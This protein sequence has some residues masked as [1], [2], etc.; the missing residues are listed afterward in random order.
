MKTYISILIAIA[1]LFGVVF[2]GYK[3]TTT[4][5]KVVSETTST[6]T[7]F[8]TFEGSVTRVFEG[9]T[10]LTYSFDIPETSTTSVSMDG[11]FTKVMDGDTFVAAVYMSYEGGRGYSPLDYI[12]EIVAQH[13]PVITP[14]GTST[15]NGHEYTRAETAGSDWYIT[16]LNNGEWLAVIEGKK[17]S[18]EAVLRI[19]SSLEARSKRQ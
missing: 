9:N 16:S 4:H 6:T 5:K 8:T 7:A 10:T 18:Q 1:V 13:V 12:T 14:L 11:A 3:Y 19:A 15:V 17:V 2:V